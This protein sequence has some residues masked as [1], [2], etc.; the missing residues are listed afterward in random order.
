[1]RINIVL[2]IIFIFI[3]YLSISSLL[4]AQSA[5]TAPKFIYVDAEG[6]GLTKEEAL[7]SAF[8]EAVRKAVGAY[9]VSNTTITSNN[10]SDDVKEQIILHSRAIISSYVESYSQNR[11]STW[12]V[13]I[14]AE[15]ENQMMENSVNAI[16]QVFYKPKDNAVIDAASK[17]QEQKINEQKQIEAQRYSEEEQR[18][19][20][21]DLINLFIKEFNM[22]NIL[23]LASYEPII[24]EEKGTLKIKVV[25]KYTDNFY[26]ELFATKLKN[27]L[28]IISLSSKELYFENNLLEKN[29]NFD[30]NNSGNLND[31]FA[32]SNIR[33]PFNDKIYIIFIVDSFSKFTAFELDKELFAILANYFNNYQYINAIADVKVFDTSTKLID[34]NVVATRLEN[35]IYLFESNRIYFRPLL[36]FGDRYNYSKEL[37]V[38]V[39]LDI[40]EADIQTKY[41]HHTVDLVV[42]YSSQ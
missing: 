18:N 3:T 23:S 25:I 31:A 27:L 15:I 26:N 35:R 5:R 38:D 33:K 28:K 10:I 32:I 41:N 36:I 40:S 19:S 11:N 39:P 2:K 12:K 37:V 24:D 29:K 34:N 1:M 17:W 7:N 9:L 30:R 22:D 16:M 42:N 14:K 6:Q 4:F 8:T 13:G 21:K 20:S